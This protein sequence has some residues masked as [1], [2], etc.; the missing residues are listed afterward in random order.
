MLEK[1]LERFAP[2]PKK[3]FKTTSQN[4]PKIDE[5]PVPDFLVSILLPMVLQGAP[6]VPNGSLIVPKM[7]APGLPNGNREKIKGAGGTGRSP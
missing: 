6:E 2:V 1:T 5:N 7:E 3:T 4:Q